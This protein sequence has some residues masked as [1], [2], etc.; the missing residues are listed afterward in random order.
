MSETLST[1]SRAFVDFIEK[2]LSERPVLPM[3]H[4]APHPERVAILSVDMIEGFCHIGPLA[5]P[6]I[7]SIVQPIV[8]LFS[9]GW[10]HGI[11]HILLSQDAHEPD[12]VEFGSWPPHCVRGTPE[13]ET[14]AAFKALPFF[15]QMVVLEKNSIHSGLNTGLNHWLEDHP[16]VDTFIVVGDCTDLCTYQLAMHLRLD[17]NAR[18]RH[19]RIIVPANAVE[20]YH[21]SIEVAQEQGGLPHDGDLLHAVFLYHMALNGIE[22][23]ARIE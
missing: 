17:A 1:R 23:V 18:Q 8:E 21:R 6:R 20:T 7:A 12:A 10:Q 16:T 19:R 15:D 2:W 5:S 4:A 14:V 3:A 9:K 11:R 22:V 13:A